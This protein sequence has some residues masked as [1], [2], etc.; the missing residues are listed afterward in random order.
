MPKLPVT[1]RIARIAAILFAIFISIFALD[2]FE[3]GVSL[4]QILIA[5]FMHLV[6]T[7]VILFILWIAWKKPQIGGVLF[8]LIGSSYFLGAKNEHILTY[9]MIVGPPILIGL[10]FLAGYFTAK[11]REV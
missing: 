1:I 10:L 9:L 3:E 2:V 11:K 5:L 6:P 8:I 7:F 4:G